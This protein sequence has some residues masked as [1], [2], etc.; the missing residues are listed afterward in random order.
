MAAKQNAVRRRARVRR[1]LL[2][3]GAPSSGTPM[4]VR[5]K[6]RVSGTGTR[7][8]ATDSAAK[9]T[10]FDTR[11]TSKWSKVKRAYYL[12]GPSMF[13]TPTAS[14]LE[15]EDVEFPARMKKIL[16]PHDGRFQ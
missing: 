14:Y 10:R 7:N 4:I 2:V 15:A 5:G 11:H 16:V 9:T 3:A 12:F 1:E 8:D 13:K 6:R